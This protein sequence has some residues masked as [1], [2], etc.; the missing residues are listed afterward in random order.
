MAKPNRKKRPPPCTPSP[1]PSTTKP[2]LTS[3]STGRIDYSLLSPPDQAIEVSNEDQ[4]DSPARN[5][6]SKV[7]LSQF[8]SG[9]DVVFLSSSKKTGSPA[10]KKTHTQSQT[11]PTSYAKAVNPTTSSSSSPSKGRSHQR[12]PPLSSIT[13]TIGSHHLI[14]HKAASSS[15]L[16][17]PQASHSHQEIEAECI[18]CSEEISEILAKAEEEGKGG[19][20]G[21]LGLWS[22][23]LAGC[24]ALFCIE[25][26]IA[27]I[28]RSTCTTPLAKPICPACTREWNVEEIRDQAKACDSSRYPA[29]APVQHIPL[30]NANTQPDTNDNTNM[31]NMNGSRKTSVTT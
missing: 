28:D 24:G 9:S 2:K 10:P 22:C 5:T 14:A 4:E 6:R 3:T 26:A 1:K 18:I 29:A 16:T 30:V 7:T 19:I 17:T 25:C 23:E 8:S 27:C 13:K 11:Y 20:G 31:H 12:I 15:T 21:G